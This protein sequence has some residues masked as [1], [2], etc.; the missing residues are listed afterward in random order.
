MRA[1]LLALLCL[2]AGPALAQEKFV[3]SNMDVRTILNFKA[4]DAAIQKLVPTGW[5]V[6]AAASGPSAGANLRVTFIDQMAAWDATGKPTTPV[7]NLVFGIPAKKKGATTGGLMIFAGLSIGVPGPYGANMKAANAVER[8]VLHTAKGS[9]VAESWE[10]KAENGSSVALELYFVRGLATRSKAELLVFA[11][12]KPD[13]Y[14]IYRY[15][16]GVDVVPSSGSDRLQK[17][18][19]KA[20]GERFAPLFDGTEQLISITSVP[21]YQR[22][23]YL[24]GS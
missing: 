23:I 4:P 22:E 14:R 15:E 8:K 10:Y 6:D 1:I 18:T 11:Q 7:R 24:P 19:F 3:S 9:I 13:F 21:W 16:Q 20:S 2:C 12:P 17:F 5:E